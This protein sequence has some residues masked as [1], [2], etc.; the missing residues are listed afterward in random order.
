MSEPKV[1]YDCGADC[2]CD[3][4][5]D[6]ASERTAL[7]EEMAAALERASRALRHIGRF[8][9]GY[10][11]RGVSTVADLALIEVDAV[12][13]KYRGKEEEVDAGG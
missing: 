7:M 1:S 11:L 5:T 3:A 9:N 2:T 8:I 13:A 12:L 6:L 4:V 10:G